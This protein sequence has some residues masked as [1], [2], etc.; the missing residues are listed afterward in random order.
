MFIAVFLLKPFC[1]LSIDI[2]S[3]FHVN[4]ML[5]YDSRCLLQ[6]LII[7]VFIYIF[8]SIDKQ[9]ARAYSNEITSYCG[10]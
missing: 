8:L 1:F 3:N 10:R 4:D 6:R 5:Q 2:L 7:F 9:E